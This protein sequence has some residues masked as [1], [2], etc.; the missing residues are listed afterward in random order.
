MHKA[1]LKCEAKNEVATETA[2]Y[3]IDVTCNF[4]FK[5]NQKNL[6]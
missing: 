6:T 4:T 1:I 3:T 2:I 5:L